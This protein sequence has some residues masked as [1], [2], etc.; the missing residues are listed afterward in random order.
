MWGYHLK[1]RGRWWHYFPAVP[2]RYLDV[3]RRRHICFSLKTQDFAVAKV[4]ASQISVDLDAEWQRA[5]KLGISLK[6]QSA[7]KRYAAGQKML[8]RRRC[9]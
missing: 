3:G 4:K 9:G 8:T 2:E 6:S 1:R 7:A 5:V